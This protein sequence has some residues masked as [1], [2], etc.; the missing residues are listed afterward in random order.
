MAAQRR[1]TGCGFVLLLLPLLAA[2]SFAGAVGGRVRGRADHAPLAA[3]RVTLQ[4]QAGPP[5]SPSLAVL[6]ALSSDA[7]GSGEG[8]MGATLTDASWAYRFVDV[9]AGDYILGFA[10]DA[11]A[12][13]IVPGI[14]IDAG[15]DLRVDADLEAPLTERVTVRGPADG[16]GSGPSRRVLERDDLENRPAAL[17]DPFRALAG[18][19]GV[20][21]GNDFQSEMRVRG[22]DAT[23]TAVLLDG[24]PLPYA[25]HFGG[26]AGSAGT[27]SG[28][29]VESVTLTTGGFSAEYGDALAGVIDLSTRV[30]H[31]G[32]TTGL[33]GLGS[34]LAHAAVFGTAGD[35]SYAVSARYGDLGLYD[36][37]VAGDAADGVR[38]HDL[39][40]ALRVPFAGGARLE[41]A[42]MEAGND[43]RAELGFSDQAV[44]SSQDRGWRARLDLPFDA[45]SL[46]RLQIADTGLA[47]RAGIDGGMGYDQD[48]RRQ[49]VRLSWSRDLGDSH[50]LNA[51]LGLQRVAGGM[52]GAVADGEVLLPSALDLR[53]DV[54]SVYLE[55]TWR[56]DPSVSLRLGGRADRSSWTGESGVSPRLGVEFHPRPR[57]VLRCAAGRFVQ[58]P[59]QEQMFLAAGTPL[60]MQSADHIIAG[61][62]VSTDRGTRLVVE[63]YRK[64]LARPIGEAVNRYVELQELMTQFDR[65]RI[66]GAEVTLRHGGE[67]GLSWEADY[68][69]L[70]ATQTKAGVE[71]PRD[72]D[73]RHTL[74]LSFGRR[75]GNGWEAGGT[76]RYATG[77]PYSPLRPWTNG[78]DYGIAVG[79][80][81]GA[82]LPAYGRVDL[83]LRRARTTSWGLL[84]VRLDI[85][86]IL[87]RRNVRSIDVAYDPA[88]GA[89]YRITHDQSPFLP[90]LGVSAEF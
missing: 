46:L 17:G 10:G 67:G 85:L 56:P 61:F 78:I 30:A 49:D 72:T 68:A 13:R 90:V 76:V 51:G 80:L 84:N 16:T 32:R 52:T 5:R 24:Q 29:L 53:S 18:T 37:H 83:S 65:G 27:L 74:G 55:D 25:Y 44:M 66:L 8:F 70:T 20:A 11:W 34:M 7:A 86:N 48:Q 47:V 12:G 6:P 4:A 88:T 39:Y 57:L 64:D 40:G 14:R 45:E 26:G 62:E 63:G 9:P 43:Y 19:A 79:D 73:Q 77:L 2:P 58:F 21:P 33:V 59:R 60:R 50:G 41:M 15:S 38:F 81:N 69:W 42:L 35:D 28:D 3:V 87:D 23:E 1:F 82:R 22:G 54:A 36:G 75:L 71:S 89:F 31:P